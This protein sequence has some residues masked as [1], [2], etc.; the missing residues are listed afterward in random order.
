MVVV[1]DTQTTQRGFWNR[2]GRLIRRLGRSLL[3]P[4]VWYLGYPVIVFVRATPVI[5]LQ[6]LATAARPSTQRLHLRNLFADGRRY[7]IR[8]KTPAQTGFTM[9][10]T[11]RVLW[12]YRRR[13]SSSA[14][15]NGTF[16][17]FGDD[18][19]RL[20]LRARVR[21]LYMFSSLFLPTFMTSI[22]IF[23]PWPPAL[24]AALIALLYAL[25]WTGYRANAAI[26]S[27]AMIW[28]VQKAL[29]DLPPVEIGSLGS[30][31]PGVYYD[32]RDFEA[33]W[34]KFYAEHGGEA[35]DGER[36]MGDRG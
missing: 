6:T 25:S 11:S 19:T 26:E 21:P 15:L 9:V 4:R 36:G 12:R 18:S 5:C 1:D 13:T 34:Q 27:H 14:V 29:E 7:F 16:S 22:L 17:S 3:L 8:P 28:F 30:Q 33:A 23:V 35:D 20:H 2:A 32:S 24:I 10:T 31:T